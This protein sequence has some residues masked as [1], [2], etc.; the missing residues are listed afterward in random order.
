MLCKVQ[1]P[2]KRR[3]QQGIMVTPVESKLSGLVLW[4]SAAEFVVTNREGGVTGKV[5]GTEQPIKLCLLRLRNETQK[6]I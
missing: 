1:K 3:K 5:L 2:L 6:V 4:L